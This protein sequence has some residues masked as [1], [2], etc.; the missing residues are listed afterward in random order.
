MDPLHRPFGSRLTRRHVLTRVLPAVVVLPTAVS[1][2]SLGQNAA[3]AP[4]P[5]PG[6]ADAARADAA[7]AAAAIAAD[8]TL[9]ARLEPLRA[10]RTT[11]AAELDR[12][13][14][15]PPATGAAARTTAPAAPSGTSS[16]KPSATPSSTARRDAPGVREVHDAIA[17]SAAAAADAAMVLPAEKVGLVAS[18]AACCST[19][20]ALL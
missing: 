12:L 17:A 8:P 15:R 13:L 20:A 10:A 5:L 9:K 18:V 7:L 4:D 1:G 11:H 16:A 19:Y 6:L 2:C 3:K 14:G